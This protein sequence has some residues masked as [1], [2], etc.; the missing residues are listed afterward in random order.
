MAGKSAVLFV[1]QNKTSENQ[2][3]GQAALEHWHFRCIELFLPQEL[4]SA[5]GEGR[6]HVGA[7]ID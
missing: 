3:S 2:A 1:E 7:C 6:V 4:G 5:T